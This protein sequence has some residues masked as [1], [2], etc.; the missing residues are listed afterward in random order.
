MADDFIG[1]ISPPPGVIKWIGNPNSIGG[2][3]PGL[4]P[5]FN[6]LLK[7]IIALAGLYAFL[8]L[9]IAGYQFMSA[10]GDSKAIGNAWSKIW[11]SLMGL[12]IVAGSFV[13]AAIFGYLIFGDASA[14]ITPKIYGPQ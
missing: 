5:F 8:N 12:L 11:Q 2:D 1:T 7:L 6:A 14:I 9:I 3:V 4:I 13:L 10:G